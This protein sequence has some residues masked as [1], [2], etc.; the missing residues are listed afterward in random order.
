MIGIAECCGQNTDVVAARRGL[1]SGLAHQG[2]DG[3]RSL[4]SRERGLKLPAYGAFNVDLGVAPFSGAWIEMSDMPVTLPNT[5]GRSLHG[6]V[7]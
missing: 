3:P 7:D 5:T 6:S 4:P 2:R 1:K